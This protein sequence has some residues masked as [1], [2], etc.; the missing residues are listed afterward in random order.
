MIESI[1]RDA[2][3]ILQ[4]A[5]ANQRDLQ[6][7][8]RS[9]S[10]EIRQESG[11]GTSST[12]TR[13][14]NALNVAGPIQTMRNEATAALDRMRDQESKA[15]RLYGQANDEYERTSTAIR[16]A[17][18]HYMDKEMEWAKEARRMYEQAAA[19]M[20]AGSGQRKEAE[21]KARRALNRAKEALSSVEQAQRDIKAL[22]IETEARLHAEEEARRITEEK[23]REA[24]IAI[25]KAKAAIQRLEDLPHG[26]FQPGDAEKVGRLLSSADTMLH[27][28]QFTEALSMATQASQEANRL[29]ETISTAWQEFQRLKAEA[30]GEAQS[31]QITMDAIDK[32]LIIAWSDDQTILKQVE[33]AMLDVRRDIDAEKFEHAA[34]QS[35]QV[36]ESLRRSFQNAAENQS[37]NEKR[38][39]IGEAIMEALE[40]I[41]FETSYAPGSRTVPLHINGQTPDVKGK[42]DFDIEIPLDGHVDFE[43]K[44]AA[45]DTSCVAAIQALQK[46]LA[47]RGIHWETTN[48]GH[49]EG[50][51][52]DGVKT[53]V[54]V[55]EKIKVKG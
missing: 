52:T 42:G 22:R 13:A 23:R 53:K 16:N 8:M 18:G 34:A 31:L 10:P 45:G 44:A 27:N 25:E 37:L 7:A 35:K 15:E 51:R 54:G 55:K 38:E 39:T 36:N 21:Q 4:Q 26:K 6:N 49:A 17:G 48:W 24:V 29:I 50:A 32:D 28:T 19:L 5:E 47:Q 3:K 2:G 14:Q 30:E 33:T 11:D 9:L 46:R 20:S 1:L 40:E 43:V 12:L 41:G